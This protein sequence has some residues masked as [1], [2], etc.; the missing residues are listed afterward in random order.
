[1]DFLKALGK[2][3]KTSGNAD[4]PEIL[5]REAELL[6]PVKPEW[7]LEI[8]QG[9][10][11]WSI[12]PIAY[13]K[14]VIC[15]FL[16]EQTY[17]SSDIVLAESTVSSPQAIFCYDNRQKTLTLVHCRK[18]LNPTMINGRPIDEH[19]IKENDQ[20]CIGFVRMTAKWGSREE[21]LLGLDDETAEKAREA[22]FC[23]H[24]LEGPDAGVAFS[25]SEPFHVIG[26][27]LA[28]RR[29][30]RPS[31]FEEGEFLALID[32]A[33]S[34]EQA[35]L[36]WKGERFEIARSPRAN[37]PM[38]V[39]RKRADEIMWDELLSGIYTPLD[40]TD[41]IRIGKTLCMMGTMEK[42]SARNSSPMETMDVEGFRE[43]LMR[44]EPITTAPLNRPAG[45]QD[46]EIPHH[47]SMRKEPATAAPES[48]PPGSMN[49]AMLRDELMRKEPA[50]EPPVSTQPYS[51][52]K[53]GL[54]YAA[55]REASEELSEEA[56]LVASI[57]NLDNWSSPI[58]GGDTEDEADE[59]ARAESIM[60][61]DNWRG[62]M[63]REEAEDTT[64]QSET[65]T[66][67][68]DSKWVL[69]IVEKEARSLLKGGSLPQ[70]PLPEGQE[71][72]A[73]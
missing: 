21:L 18:A 64:A 5:L 52:S 68:K 46:R 9:R 33:I 63:L 32:P 48:A 7:Y 36:R 27:G 10:Q 41:Q 11:E 55:P 31:A 3:T 15:R 60:N 35:F 70:V 73:R 26:R 30:D 28:V 29:S 59:G 14:M 4:V 2:F 56:D 53:E 72:E 71:E 17:S 65:V 57:M 38:E 39:G 23:I 58:L 49:M 45:S 44:K 51:S 42:I 16:R 66:F 6:E 24:V 54:N 12:I 50:N 37:V 1:M 13:K 61:Q 8:T 20:I 62:T 40:K 43:A 34:R 19:R 67:M 69:R 22:A 25:L 47:A